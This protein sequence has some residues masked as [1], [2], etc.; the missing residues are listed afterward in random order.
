M[1]QSMPTA[2]RN[3]V[4]A[5]L[6]WAGP[7]FVGRAL[8]TVLSALLIV[9][10]AA[11]AAPGSKS[12]PPAKVVPSAGATTAP[13]T[14]ST[15]PTP[16]LESS[17][18][19]DRKTKSVTPVGRPDPAPKKRIDADPRDFKSSVVWSDGVELRVRRIEQRTSIAVGRGG[20][21]GAP[22]TTFTVQLKNGSKRAL[23]ATGVV[24][25]ATYGGRSP[26][27]ASPVYDERSADFAARVAPGKSAGATYSFT[28]PRG[29]L[30]AVE[31]SFD[32]D[33]RHGI[34]TFR[35]AAR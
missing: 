12:T 6:G 34:G 26:R 30:D 19:P 23:D 4:D 1:N 18:P 17:P 33:S 27:L 9:V 5:G 16:S 3:S 7:L 13:D 2:A 8:G 28:I 32:L 25:T 21:N 35:G 20:T 14:K 22:V 31:L 10:L 24:V 15:K 11:C 29:T